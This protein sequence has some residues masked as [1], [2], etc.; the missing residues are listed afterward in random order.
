MK[1]I[2]IAL[3]KLVS[4]CVLLLGIV[5]LAALVT[6]GFPVI[7]QARVEYLSWPPFFR[8]AA[9]VIA[10]VALIFI[11]F[12]G[13]MPWGRKRRARQV[14]FAG[15]HGDVFYDLDSIENTINRVVGRMPEV[16]SIA[17][18]VALADDRRVEV[19]ADVVLNPPGVSA[20]DAASL[21]SRQIE[22]AA[23]Q[24]LGEDGV[25]KVVL[26]IKKILVDLRAPLSLAPEPA[27]PAAPGHEAVQEFRG[28]EDA[29]RRAREEREAARE[30]QRRDREERQAVRD[31]AASVEEVPGMPGRP[32]AVDLEERRVGQEK[33]GAPV[34]N[35]YEASGAAPVSPWEE[36]VAPGEPLTPG[37]DEDRYAYLPEEEEPR[38]GSD[39]EEE[40]LLPGRTLEE[41]PLP[42]P[43]EP[44]DEDEEGRGV[45]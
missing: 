3:L 11:G 21:V 26:H 9:W 45:R 27:A 25:T 6:D 19:S 32:A 30:E 43:E 24:M 20:R 31:R 42:L 17:S 38:L 39:R 1:I 41:T 23:E 35:E 14:S 37:T 5:L 4:A 8:M 34:G 10:G 22:R 12:I 18:H 33:F 29:E 2:Q 15:P 28:I 44:V 16:K 7:D 40:P 13:L 36:P